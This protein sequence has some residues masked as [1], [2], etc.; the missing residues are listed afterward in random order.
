MEEQGGESFNMAVA[1]LMR[2]DGIL[3]QMQMV[4]MMTT[5][6]KEQKLQIKLMRH[7]FSNA[8]P[9]MEIKMTPEEYDQYKTNIFKIKISMR[10]IKGK[11][12]EIYSPHL[13]DQ[14]ISLVMEIQMR[15]KNYFMPPARK[16]R[17]F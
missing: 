9:L 8:S 3:K 10:I 14:M 6:L 4:S 11:Y 13:D 2:L 16:R 7:F 17:M 5:G 12:R 15:L 1:T